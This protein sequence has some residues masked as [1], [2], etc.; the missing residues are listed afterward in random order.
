MVSLVEEV[1][2]TVTNSTTTG[3]KPLQTAERHKRES[4][5]INDDQLIGTE[6]GEWLVG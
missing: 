6:D 3:I 1:N 2:K 5:C 4:M